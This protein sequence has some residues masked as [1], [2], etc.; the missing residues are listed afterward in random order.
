MEYR[1][2]NQRWIF[3]PGRV[4]QSHQFQFLLNLTHVAY[5][6]YNFCTTEQGKKLLILQ[7]CSFI[8]VGIVLLEVD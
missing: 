1:G 8:H 2:I 6:F 7:Y 5:I 4:T 3:S